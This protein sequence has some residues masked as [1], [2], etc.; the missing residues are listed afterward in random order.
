MLFIGKA[1]Y[2][3]CNLCG[4]EIE[5]SGAALHGGEGLHGDLYGFFIKAEVRL[6][7]IVT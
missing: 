4:S 7:A 1:D 6:D 3:R 2:W 5:Y